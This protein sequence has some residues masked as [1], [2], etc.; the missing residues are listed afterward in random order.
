[1]A[2]SGQRK[3]RSRDDGGS[4]FLKKKSRFL[5]N[6][7][8]HQF[9]SWSHCVRHSVNFH[10]YE[11][12]SL[13]L[14]ENT[15]HREQTKLL[16]KVQQQSYKQRDII[17]H[18][19]AAKLTVDFDSSHT[20]IPESI[21]DWELVNIRDH[22]ILCSAMVERFR[23]INPKVKLFRLA[24]H[25]SRL[26]CRNYF[27][28]G[29]LPPKRQL[30]SH[31][32][33]MRI[34]RTAGL[35]FPPKTVLRP[36]PNDLWYQTSFYR[37]ICD[38][39]H[40][41]SMEL[42]HVAKSVVAT[43]P[44][45][46]A[47]RLISGCKSLNSRLNRRADWRA[48]PSSLSLTYRV[49]K[50]SYNS[51][52]CSASRLVRRSSEELRNS[53]FYK[54]EIAKAQVVTRQTLV[55][56][57]AVAPTNWQLTLAKRKRLEAVCVPQCFEGMRQ[58]LQPP[59]SSTRASLEKDDFTSSYRGN[60]VES[61]NKFH[62]RAR[63]LSISSAV[64]ID[65]PKLIPR[66]SQQRAVLKIGGVRLPEE[67]RDKNQWRFWSDATT[68]RSHVRH[69]HITANVLSANRARV[70]LKL[71]TDTNKNDVSG[72]Y[73]LASMSRSDTNERFICSIRCSFTI[74][75]DVT[76]NPFNFSKAEIVIADLQLFPL[77]RRMRMLI[78]RS[79]DKLDLPLEIE[80]AIRPSTRRWRIWTVRH[81]SIPEHVPPPG[82]P[83]RSY[84][85]AVD[86]PAASFS[87][88]C[89]NVRGAVACGQ[90]H[91]HLIVSYD[92]T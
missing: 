35:A 70:K 38:R 27:G 54:I 37:Y 25:Y 83:P 46:A 61:A 43:G 30:E 16:T 45:L 68:S 42:R 66:Y 63:A 4:R 59:G 36:L 47:V 76:I 12:V 13:K 85:S 73:Y 90:H 60:A 67:G 74:H 24:I 86:A 18:W 1:M 10:A 92:Q 17:A 23:Y 71:V 2:G 15:E 44:E 5:V 80:R 53:I 34:Y 3:G 40:R 72:E 81:L 82:S 79:E 91:L 41:S 11:T 20:G 51:Y 48:R 89:R 39:I 7:E 49:N 31:K 28:H 50:P 56:R 88:F 22:R 14:F 55:G 33:A 32:Y 52:Y 9:L 69:G 87:R 26:T 57:V 75:D 21:A 58:V 19:L 62:F 29:E 8:C 77:K 84:R 6:Y 78:K 64:A 65:D